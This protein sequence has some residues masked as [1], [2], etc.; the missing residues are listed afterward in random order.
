MN[1]F[2]KPNNISSDQEKPKEQETTRS[3]KEIR[4]NFEDAF[5]EF[6]NTEP[7]IYFME[8]FSE[9]ENEIEEMKS[10]IERAKGKLANEGF[11]NNAPEELVE[12]ERAKKQ[13]Y[14]SELKQL[15]ER[16]AQLKE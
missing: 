11:V 5:S 2:E 16:L 1:S 4:E 7:D 15:Q 12:E 6:M 8:N 14:E 13:K 10:E 3:W 9:I